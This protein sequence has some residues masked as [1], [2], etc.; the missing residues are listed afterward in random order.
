LQEEGKTGWGGIWREALRVDTAEFYAMADTELARRIGGALWLGGG[1]VA[2]VLLPLAPPTDTTLGNWGWLI[3]VAVVL[4][5]F[6]YGRR[7]LSPTAEVS[8]NE[9]LALDYVGVVLIAVLMWLSGAH[10]P[11]T[12]LLL[13][14]SFYTAAVH[15]PRRTLVFLLAV[16]LALASPLVYEP[17]QTLADQVARMLIWSGLA[18]VATFFTARVRLER[19][20]LV[21]MGD[22]A[23]SEARVD[24]LTGLG[25]RRAFDEA[26]VAASSRSE[27]TGSSL[28]VI[29]VDVDSFKSINDQHGLPAGDRC[30]HEV[31]AVLSETLRQPD[32]CFRWGGDEF[33]VVA[34]VDRTGAG[35]LAERIGADVQRRCRRPTGEPVRLHVGVAELNVDGCNADELLAAA[36]R[37]LKPA[38]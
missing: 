3:G 9:I 28:S 33:A 23:R 15:P 16:A 18:I 26:L 19:A 37:M 38:S 1:L 10:S 30:L 12:E 8:P 27:R 32:A 2:A 6:A 34:D 25:N 31:A 4:F 21:A 35:S 13:I 36:S 24:P 22:E 5:S 14:V 7:L 17:D 11:Y 29:I 20:R